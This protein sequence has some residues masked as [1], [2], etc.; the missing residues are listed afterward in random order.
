MGS[1]PDS[2]IDPQYLSDPMCSII[3]VETSSLRRFNANLRG[4][5][6]LLP[7]PACGFVVMYSCPG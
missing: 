3:R 4:M 2:D 5:L 1:C 6:L 7:F